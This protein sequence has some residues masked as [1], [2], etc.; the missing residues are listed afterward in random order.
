MFSPG[1][2]FNLRWTLSLKKRQKISLEPRIIVNVEDDRHT[3]KVDRVWIHRHASTPIDF[4]GHTPTTRM[5]RLSSL[6]IEA[7]REA[8]DAELT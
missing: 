5:R 6:S 7:I 3:A 4:E 2:D 1:V 8:A